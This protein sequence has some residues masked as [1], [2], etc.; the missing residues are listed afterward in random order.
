M[1]VVQ[2]YCVS[3]KGAGTPVCLGFTGGGKAGTECAIW[4][5]FAAAWMLGR[6]ATTELLARHGGGAGGTYAVDC[7]GFFIRVPDGA[8]AGVV[9]AKAMLFERVGEGLINRSVITN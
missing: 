6:N 3:G 1:V 7:K 9:L 2:L 8:P 5:R 4:L